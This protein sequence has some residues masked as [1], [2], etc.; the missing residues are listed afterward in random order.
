M[1]NGIKTQIKGYITVIIEPN[2]SH[3]SVTNTKE[4]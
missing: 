2:A 1:E 4:I 3:V